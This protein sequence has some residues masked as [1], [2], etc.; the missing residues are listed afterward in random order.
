[1]RG[2]QRCRPLR[3]GAR[4]AEQD[5]G[6]HQQADHGRRKVRMPAAP[7][8]PIGALLAPHAHD[9]GLELVRGREQAGERR[10]GALGSGAQRRN[11]GLEFR[12]G[13]RGHAAMV[14]ATW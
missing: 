6:E 10:A 11:V 7:L 8:R 1:M 14:G 5:E 2:R 9:L 4:G 12:N 13:A 3:F